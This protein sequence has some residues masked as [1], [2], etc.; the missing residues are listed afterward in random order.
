MLPF[1]DNRSPRADV[2]GGPVSTDAED[3]S[4]KWKTLDAT[5][6]LG[7]PCAQPLVYGIVSLFIPFVKIAAEAYTSQNQIAD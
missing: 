7:H 6:C 1:Y 4:K 2:D 5:I 3:E